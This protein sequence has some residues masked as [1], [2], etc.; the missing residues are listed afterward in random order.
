MVLIGILAERNLCKPSVLIKITHLSNLICIAESK[1]KLFTYFW[2][3]T[4]DRD[5]A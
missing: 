1:V 5:L 2:H 4:P 3:Q